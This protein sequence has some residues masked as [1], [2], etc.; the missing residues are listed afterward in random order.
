M[1]LA[2]VGVGLVSP[3]GFTSSDHV[4]FLRAGLPEPQASPFV[5]ADG[6]AIRVAYCPW[7]GA[8]TAVGDRMS[9]MAMSAL[10][11]AMAPV[12]CGPGLGA[13]PLFLCMGRPRAGLS[14]ADLAEVEK[15]LAD[16]MPGS[17][18]TRFVGEAGAFA[19]ISA[20]DE[21]I[22][23]GRA[24]AVGILAVDSL[25]AVDALAFI[26]THPPSPWSARRLKSSEAAAA[27]VVTSP[28]EARSSGLRVIG[29]LRGAAVAKGTSC[30]DDDTMVDGVGMSNALRALPAADRIGSVFGQLRVDSLRQ[31]EWVLA[32]A[33][34]SERFNHTHEVQ[35]PE[36]HT[37]A[38]GAAAGAFNVVYGLS[39]FNHEAAE[40]T[41]A[42]RAPF[43]AWAISPDGTRGVA[44]ATAGDS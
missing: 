10:Y 11:E 3:C 37:G 4:F 36:A 1:R 6:E 26:A 15:R 13:I 29:T 27:L 25:I 31:S 43:L 30:D 42:S 41:E 39:V 44:L 2:V 9:R 23:S 28:V 34:N 14:E 38:L 12:Q 33:R 7:I 8:R 21:L 24:R 5:G 22:T 19:A 18:V 35:S 40:S 20:A 17:T 16:R 32:L